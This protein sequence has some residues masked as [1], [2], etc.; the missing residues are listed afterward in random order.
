MS[1]NG[2]PLTHGFMSAMETGTKDESSPKNPLEAFTL[3]GRL[4]VI[5]S[6]MVA[7][8]IFYWNVIYISE[9]FPSGIY[10]LTFLL[11]PSL[12][13]SFLFMG[14]ST[15]ILSLLKIP[16]RKPPQSMIIPAHSSQNPSPDDLENPLDE[17]V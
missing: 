14:I 8:G 11:I 13:G 4:L 7:G 5:A 16:T 1:W 3:P 15:L 10:P 12:M 17:K 6:I 9:N 2:T